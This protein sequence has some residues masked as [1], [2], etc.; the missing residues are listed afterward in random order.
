MPNRPALRYDWRPVTPPTPLSPAITPGTRYYVA[1]PFPELSLNAW[2]SGG[3]WRWGILAFLPDG[4]GVVFNHG[5]AG[6]LGE[7]KW[8]AERAIP[9]NA[10]PA[11][12]WD[13]KPAKLNPDDL[14][15]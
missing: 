5:T 12:I 3:Y 4:M 9:R 7:A 1:N 2:R 15:F 6:T 14:P 11:T 13:S 8:Y 10:E